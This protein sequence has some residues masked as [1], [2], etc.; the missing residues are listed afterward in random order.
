MWGLSGSGYCSTNTEAGLGL[1]LHTPEGKF[2]SNRVRLYVERR[3]ETGIC[4]CAGTRRK[5]YIEVVKAR[6]CMPV[7]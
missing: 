2:G 4:Y 1:I 6:R 5:A 3:I 7:A